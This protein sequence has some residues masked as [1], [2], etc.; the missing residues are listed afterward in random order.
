[1]PLRLVVES[2]RDRWE[3]FGIKPKPSE[4]TVR[5]FDPGENPAGEVSANENVDGHFFFEATD[6]RRYRWVAQV[7]DEHALSVA[8]EVA[9]ALARP[10]PNDAEWLRRAF[11]SA[12][13]RDPSPD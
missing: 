6:E 5:F 10:G 12:P 7:K 4:L 8:G 2:Q 1:M 3:Y 13:E 11:G 9:A